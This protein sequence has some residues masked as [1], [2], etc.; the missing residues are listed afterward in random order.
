MAMPCARPVGPIM[1]STQEA[2]P[3]P[4]A[5]TTPKPTAA[6]TRPKLTE[7][8][9]AKTKLAETR[10]KL[11][12]TKPAET[13]PKLTETKRAETKPIASAK[14]KPFDPNAPFPQ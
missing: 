9:P 7:T 1:Q 6:E 8:K 5:T 2:K 12:E 4:I 14:P 11:T 3:T 10:P 13:R